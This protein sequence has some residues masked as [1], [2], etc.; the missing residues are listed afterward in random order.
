M[1]R[2]MSARFASLEAYVPGEQPQDRQYVKLNTNESPFPPSPQV[3]AAVNREQVEGLN[4]Y[5]DPECR[6]LRSKLA[7]RYQVKEE[8]VFLANGSDDVL[9]FAFM[10]FCDSA[11]PVAFPDISYGFY[12]VYARLHNIPAR[13]IPLREGFVLAAED[14]CGLGCNIVLANPNAP[15]GRAIPVEDVE[16]IL[17]ANPDHVVVVDE[18]YVDFGS[19]AAGT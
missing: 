13:E 1:S 11:R 19:S 2:Y 4:L 3:V 15:S 17:R 10:A 12:P 14:Y 5:P 9:N 8:Q 18:A 6:R 16:K 7:A